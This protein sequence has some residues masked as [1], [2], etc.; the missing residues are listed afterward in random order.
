MVQALKKIKVVVRWFTQGFFISLRRSAGAGR[1]S[2]VQVLEL[3]RV[4]LED[5][6]MPKQYSPL[7][8][9]HSDV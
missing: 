4:H 8:E 6:W 1:I 7:V 5:P 2:F 9:R 3:S